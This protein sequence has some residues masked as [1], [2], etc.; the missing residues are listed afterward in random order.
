MPLKEGLYEQVVTLA[1][2]GELEALN[3]LLEAQCMELEVGDSHQVLA[4]HLKHAIGQALQIAAE[5]AGKKLDAQIALCNQ[6]IG[7][8]Q[9]AEG[10]DLAR[11]ARKLLEIKRQ[12]GPQRLRPD[13]PLTTA[14]L[15][16]GTRLDPS[17]LSQLSKELESADRLDILC[18]FIKWSGIRTMENELVRFT[19]RE[20]TRLRVITTSYMGATDLKAVDF[21]AELPNTQVRL[22]FDTERTRLHAKSYTFHRETGFGTS[23]IG[24]ANLT[25]PA[26]TDG[27][28]WSVKVSQYESPGLWE[29]IS[30]TFE[31]YWQDPEFVLYSPEQRERLQVAL[32]HEQTRDAGTV[33]TFFDLR[34][35][36]FQQEIL[37]KL[38]AERDVSGR[39]RQL[40]V[41]ATGT[42]KT[43]IAAFDYRR[44]C[45]SAARKRLLFIAHREEI[46]NQ[47]LHTFRAVLRN[48]NF[49]DKLVGG[50]RPGQDE[51]LFCS[52]QS[53][54]SQEMDQLPPDFYDY[55]VVDE[56]HHSAAP[57]Y[58]RLLSHVRPKVLLGLTATP[59]RTDQEDILHYFG[60]HITSEIRLPD[61]I[62]RK[63]LCPFQYFGISDEVD[64]SGL[65]WQRGGYDLNE[66]TALLSQTERA[67]LVIRSMHKILLDPCEARGLAFC[68]SIRH[69]QFMAEQLRLAGI[70]AIALSAD[71]PRDERRAVQGQLRERKI[72]FICTVDLYNEGVDIPEVDTVLFLRPTE[73]LTVFLQQLGRG[74]RLQDDKECLTVLD[75][76]G[77]AHKNFRYDLRFRALMGDAT[78]SVAT[79]VSRG[80]PHLPAG[81]TIQLERFARKY[82]LDNIRQNIQRNTASLADEVRAAGDSIGGRPSLAQ[83]LSYAQLQSDDIYRRKVTY[84][85]LCHEAGW[86]PGL[87]EPDEPLLARGLRRLQHTDSPSVIACVHNAATHPQTT[88]S[89]ECARLL[90]MMHMSLWS[91]DALPGDLRACDARLRQNPAHMG[92]LLELLDYRKEQID[93]VRKR[94]ELPFFCPLDLHCQY[95]RDEILAG[96]GHWTLEAQPSMREGVL[97]LRE[98]KADLFFITLNKTET[99]YS[100]TTMYEDYA[101]SPELF[102]WQSQSTTTPESPVGQR[103]IHHRETGHT[104]LLFVRENRATSG[105]ANPYFYLGPADYVS[106]QGARPISFVFRLRYS[107]P[108]KLARQTVRMVN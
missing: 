81:C 107:M 45:E 16:T 53:W 102:H 8:L 75:F 108:A 73:S 3:P 90:T 31:T 39:E 2:A 34:P 93:S 36:P 48:N 18:S 94:P 42:G 105:L 40:V 83:F 27:L 62:N 28:E 25:R 37:D 66:L 88:Y 38:Q 74:L 77:H 56:F 32:R 70:P 58:E 71:S 99:D 24:S 26:I 101:I 76:I 57:T 43:M 55:V 89:E 23:Y 61:A 1:L 44:W 60:G 5:G 63:L 4:Q 67:G 13:T 20:H 22:T 84:T 17:L 12:K 97:Y 78:Q 29:K 98:Q 59:E 21:L 95:T 33:D 52:I 72:N 35:Y 100:P 49:G 91:R 7:L 86:L 54:N 104:I 80:F 65:R 103:Y 15:L 68:A 10:N 14:C 51:H 106:H 46:L 9:G 96:V 87:S 30:G 69:A 82:V 41:A 92:E 85:R 6:I 64:L 79:Q 47:S 50:A 19:E 11:P